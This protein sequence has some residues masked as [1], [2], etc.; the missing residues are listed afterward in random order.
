MIAERFN[1]TAKQAGAEVRTYSLHK[2]RFLGCQACQKCKQGPEGECVLRDDLTEVLNNVHTADI[3]V[4]AT[5]VYYG[6]VNHWVGAFLERTYS[7][8]RPDFMS[9]PKP[10]RLPPGKK[11]VFI[12]VQGAAEGLYTDIFRRYGVFFRF[13]GFDELHLIRA[14]DTNDPGQ[15]ATRPDILS[16]AEDLARRLCVPTGQEQKQRDRPQRKVTGET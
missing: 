7:Y 5:P 4:I 6:D 10:C 1:Q 2:I 12:Q 15:I 9:N 3:L 14:C 8:L 11:L 13:D 16:Q